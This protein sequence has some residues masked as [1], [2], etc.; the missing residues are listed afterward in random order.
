M[1]WPKALITELVSRRCVVF[2]GSGASAGCLSQDGTIS[3][4]TWS[5]FLISLIDLMTDK[6]DLPIIQEFIQKEKYLEAAEIIKNNIPPADFSTFIRESFVT[7]RFQPSAM[8]EA[9]LEID[10]KIVITTN[11]DDIYDTFCRK[12][13]AHEGYNISKYYDNHIISVLRSPVRLI[14]KAHG[15]ISEPSQI[16]LTKSEYFRARQSFSSFYKVLDSLFLTH[17]ILFLGYSLT[18]PD[19]QLLLENVNIAAPS[20]H[21]HYFVTGNNINPAIKQA[22]KKAYNIDFIEYT[23]GNFVELNEGLNDLSESVNQKRFANPSV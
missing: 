12:G 20:S 22:N 10:P 21:P 13:T 3:P 1:N 19:I 6:I 23:A 8:H 14:I 4:P 2:I 11:Y 7:P 16:V 17:T 18:D 5:G 9:I 15:C